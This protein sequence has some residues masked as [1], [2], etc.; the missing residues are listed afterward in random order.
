MADQWLGRWGDVVPQP[1]FEPSIGDVFTKE[2]H[3][4][5]RGNIPRQDSHAASWMRNF[6]DRLGESSSAYGI[7]VDQADEVRQT[8]IAF[9]NALARSVAPATRT[10][11]AVLKKNE[12]RAEAERVCRGFYS[13]IRANVTVSNDDLFAAGIRPRS[14]GRA[15]S[16]APTSSPWLQIHT[17][18]STHTIRWF[19]TES[20]GRGKPAGCAMLQLFA[21]LGRREATEPEQ[22]RLVNVYTCNRVTLSTSGLDPSLPGRVFDRDL[23]DVATFFA[24]RA[25]PK[26][27]PGPWSQPASVR[28][29]A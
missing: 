23:G 7:T 27:Q 20:A 29:A 1:T 12:C 3:G 28:L 24:R 5:T 13:M 4:M 14:R 2:R 16:S 25:G 11:L 18:N 19:D 9:R 17:V 8:V 15:R 6:A 10:S 26:G 22:A 21:T